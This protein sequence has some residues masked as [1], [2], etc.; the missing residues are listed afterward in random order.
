MK[1]PGKRRFISSAL[2]GAGSIV[3]ITSLTACEPNA[4]SDINAGDGG[5]SPAYNAGYEFGIRLALFQQQQPGTGPDEALKGMCDALSDTNQTISPADM[6]GRLQPGEV[7]PFENP[8]PPQTETGI[9]PRNDDTLV[10]AGYEIVVALPSG[11]KYQV[12]QAGGGEQPQAGDAVIVS[13]K[14]YLDDGSLFG[15]TSERRISLDEIAVPGLKEAL[16]LMNEG[17][18]WQVVVPP[19]MGFT[20]SGNRTLRRS[21]L[22]YDIELI[23]I[24]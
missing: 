23:S 1:T 17:A 21:N 19:N 16:L 11:V 12:L 20:K 14:T 8:E 2:A 5:T 3:L 24:E 6:C 15:S 4:D 18:R 22:T 9:E 10:D 13:Y 7:R